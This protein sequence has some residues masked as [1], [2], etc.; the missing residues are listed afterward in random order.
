MASRKKEEER[1]G[2]TIAT[3]VRRR[4]TAC[5]TRPAR[6]SPRTLSGL[7]ILFAS[8]GRRCRQNDL[9]GAAR[10]GI[11]ARLA[12]YGP[13]RRSNTAHNRTNSPA[14]LPA[15]QIL[16]AMQWYNAEVRQ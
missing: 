12:D 9:P 11:P 5:A 15:L 6:L 2:R 7:E 13:P 10:P 16:P 8:F 3:E 4:A 14:C 1:I